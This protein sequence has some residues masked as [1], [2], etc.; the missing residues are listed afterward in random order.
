MDSLGWSVHRSRASA[1]TAPMRNAFLRELHWHSIEVSANALFN[2]WRVN[3]PPQGEIRQRLKYLCAI[4]APHSGATPKQTIFSKHLRR[5]TSGWRQQ[6]VPNGTASSSRPRND[7]GRRHQTRGHRGTG[8]P[9]KIGSSSTT[10]IFRTII[11]RR[12]R[13]K[14]SCRTSRLHRSTFYIASTL[15]SA[16]RNQR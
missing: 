11:H 10:S 13:Q 12:G 5:S 6:L 16:S 7:S 9:A 2:T 8:R 1:V 4:L 3:C 14:A 15:S